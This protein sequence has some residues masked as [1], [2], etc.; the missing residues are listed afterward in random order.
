MQQAQSQDS[1]VHPSDAFKPEWLVSSQSIHS[2]GLM[3]RHH[4]EPADE[5]DLPALTHHC[6]ILVLSS[7]SSRQVTQFD[8]HKYDGRQGNHGEFWLL[9]AARP[10]VFAWD[11]TDETIVLLLEPTQLAHVATETEFVNPDRMEL[12]PI[13]IA[14]DSQVASVQN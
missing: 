7:T 8:G 10:G 3:V 6:L 9:P 11:G 2:S 4:I 12:L 5:I 13:L 14:N 1:A